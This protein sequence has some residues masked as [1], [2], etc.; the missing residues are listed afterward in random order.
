M[1]E[2][3]FENNIDLHRIFVYN[4]EYHICKTEVDFIKHSTDTSYGNEAFISFASEFLYVRKA[5]K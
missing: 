5:S 4:V 3:T 2:N 1:I